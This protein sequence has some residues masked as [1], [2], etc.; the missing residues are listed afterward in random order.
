MRNI[1][2]IWTCKLINTYLQIEHLFK[3]TD[4][5]VSNIL[6]SNTTNSLVIYFDSQY[7]AQKYFNIFPKHYPISN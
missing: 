5:F 1:R 3:S 7:E 4:G 6:H 2:S